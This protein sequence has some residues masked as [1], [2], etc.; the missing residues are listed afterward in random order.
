MSLEKIKLQIIKKYEEAEKELLD[1]AKKKAKIINDSALESIKQI[2]SEL[3]Q[4]SDKES[5]VIMDREKS[6]AKMEVQ[7]MEFE[8]RKEMIDSVYK[9]AYEKI[10]SMP[11]S[12]REGVIKKLIDLAGREISVDV[13]YVNESDR[14]FCEGSAQ[15][16]NLA[17]DGGIICE[18]KDGNVRVNYT[19]E[20]MFQDVKDNTIKEVSNILFE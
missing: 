3:S 18:T 17:V 14:G 11:Q 7:K 10:R 13:I 2:E 6:L 1:E 16:K 15:I 9:S 8:V 5:R 4:R 19:F 20:S 12:D